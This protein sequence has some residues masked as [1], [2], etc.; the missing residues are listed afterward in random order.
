MCAVCHGKGGEG[1]A[2]DRAPSLDNPD[3]LATASPDFLR[4]AIENGR[5]GSTMSAWSRSRGGPLNSSEVDSLVT[6][7]RSWRPREKVALDES[8]LNGDAAK[9]AATFSRE[10]KSCHGE[11]GVGGTYVQI[12]SPDLL[13]SA[14]NGFLRYAIRRGRSPKGMPSFESTLGDAAIDDVIAELRRLQKA[15]TPTPRPIAAKAPPLPLG[16]VPLNPK[17]PEPVGFVKEPGTT[18]ADVIKREL[19]RGAKMA[20]LDARAPSDFMNEHIAGAVSVP[21]YD[22]D[23]Y[24]SELPKDAWLVCYCACPHAESGTLAHK[25]TAAGFTKVTVLDQGLGYWRGHKYP[26][27]SSPKE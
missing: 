27:E 12:G 13:G 11:H 10:C 1:Y 3:F 4:K 6:A 5:T 25:L 8:P 22:P 24:F 19:D 16:P 9:G 15:A 23:P 18:S 7:I 17:G 2:A 21:F 14:T 26:L 20:V